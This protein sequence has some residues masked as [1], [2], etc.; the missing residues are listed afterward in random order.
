MQICQYAHISLACHIIAVKTSLTLACMS[1]HFSFSVLLSK[2]P[3]L[4]LK[5]CVTVL[6]HLIALVCASYQINLERRRNCPCKFLGQ[7]FHS[8]SDTLTCHIFH[9]HRLVFLPLLS[10]VYPHIVSVAS[11]VTKFVNLYTKASVS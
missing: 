11:H 9:C 10:H 8:S 5:F 7:P 3:G 1:L 2:S 6:Q 4:P